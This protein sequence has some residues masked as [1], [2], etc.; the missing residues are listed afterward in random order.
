MKPKKVLGLVLASVAGK[1][2]QDAL[3]VSFAKGLTNKQAKRILRDMVYEGLEKGKSS[4]GCGHPHQE[5]EDILPSIIE[6]VTYVAG[7]LLTIADRIRINDGL[8]T[9][10]EVIELPLVDATSVAKQ[11][12][13]ISIVVRKGVIPPCI[14][15]DGNSKKLEDFKEVMGDYGIVFGDD[16]DEE[17]KPTAP[18]E[19]NC[20]VMLSNVGK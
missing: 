14:L 2:L 1:T 4:T 18:T 17:Q 6:G 7:M 19:Q 11:D 3:T 12:F 13:T 16:K 20:S 5:G 15:A 8:D 10:P 9:T